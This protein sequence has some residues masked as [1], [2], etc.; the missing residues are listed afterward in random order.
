[1]HASNLALGSWISDSQQEIKVAGEVNLDVDIQGE[2]NS[3]H[4]WISRLDGGVHFG[5]ENAR[6]PRKYVEILTVDVFGWALGKAKIKDKYALLDCVMATFDIDKGVAKSQLLI[7]DGPNL[8]IEGRTTLNFGEE[9]MDMVLLPKQKKRWYSDVSALHIKGPMVNPKVTAVP[10]KTAA[11]KIGTLV[12]MLGVAIPVFMV[13]ELRSLFGRG[14]TAST[15][16]ESV[17]ATLEG[18]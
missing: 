4:E 13:G 18:Q 7:A 16:C 11:T 2:G 17:V 6:I 8:S 12:F 14:E 3:F 5:L 9:S 1:M 15:G 10:K